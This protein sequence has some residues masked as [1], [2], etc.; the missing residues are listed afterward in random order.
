MR[1]DVCGAEPLDMPMEA[2]AVAFVSNE[3][4]FRLVARVPDS[5][6]GIDLGLLMRFFPVDNSSETAWL[7]FK[8]WESRE[9]FSLV[10]PTCGVNSPSFRRRR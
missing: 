9:P 8:V 10:N 1:A 3:R 4:C 7:F 6:D 5:G 2:A